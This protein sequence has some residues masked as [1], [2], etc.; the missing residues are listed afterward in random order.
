MVSG[1]WFYGLIVVQCVNCMKSLFG[2]EIDTLTKLEDLE[3]KQALVKET[4]NWRFIRC[5]GVLGLERGPYKD[6]MI[7]NV[8]L[9]NWSHSDK[10]PTP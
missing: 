3:W 9:Y 4:L 10:S 8:Y 5:C 7:Y 6:Y 1:S 2:I